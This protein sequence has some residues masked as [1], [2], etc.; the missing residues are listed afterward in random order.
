AELPRTVDPARLIG[1]VLIVGYGRVG[2]RIAQALEREGLT[3]V[4]AEENRAVVEALRARGAHAVSGDASDP[5]VLIQ[6]HVA[7]ARL[8]VVASP[9]TLKARRM[10]ELARTLN[11]HIEVVLRT[12]SDEEAILLAQEGLGSV[13]MGEQELASAMTRHVL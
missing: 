12:H 7:R 6:A 9:D 8:L 4:V 2:R 1:H 13:F 10:I 11:P 3:Y 5:A